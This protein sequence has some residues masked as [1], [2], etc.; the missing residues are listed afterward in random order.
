MLILLLSVLAVVSP[1][2]FGGK[3][4]RLASVRLTAV[5]IPVTAL[6]AQ[7]VIIEVIPEAPRSIL[8]GVHLATY[9]AAGA[10]VLLNLRVPGLAIIAVGAL[11]NGVTIALN[12][13]ALPA[14][15]AAQRAAGITETPGEFINSATVAH[16]VLPWLGDVFAWPTPMPLHNVFSLGD[17]VI[18]FGAFYGAQKICGS[19]LVKGSAEAAIDEAVALANGPGASQPADTQSPSGTR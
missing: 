13:G 8:V 7:V 1:V 14:S 16:P 11:M 18:V 17:V 4:S 5:W 2:L 12:G 19:R 10:F 15:A 6:V 3:L 9:L